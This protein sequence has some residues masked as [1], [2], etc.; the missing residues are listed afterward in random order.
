MSQETVTTPER[1]AT[2][3]TSTKPSATDE[4][5]VGTGVMNFD[6]VKHLLS[7][8]PLRP[9]VKRQKECK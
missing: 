9:R 8:K 2:I 5:T 1:H 3:R 4:M 6:D 7:D